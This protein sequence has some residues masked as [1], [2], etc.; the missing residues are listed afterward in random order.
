[1]R[2]DIVAINSALRVVC[3][4]ARHGKRGGATI[5]WPRDRTAAPTP[6]RRRAI[7]RVGVDLRITNRVVEV[8]DLIY[9]S[10]GVL[11]RVAAKNMRSCD[12]GPRSL[13]S[14]QRRR[15]PTATGP[16]TVPHAAAPPRPTAA[17]PAL[18]FSELSNSRLRSAL[19]PLRQLPRPAP[20]R[21]RALRPWR[22][23]FGA[24]AHLAAAAL[25]AAHAL[26]R[27]NQERSVRELA[28]TGHHR[29]DAV[30]RASRARAAGKR[31]RGRGGGVREARAGEWR[32]R[33]WGGIGRE[34]SVRSSVCT[35]TGWCGLR[36]RKGFQPPRR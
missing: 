14:K 10:V 24:L 33:G 1:M 22:L 28:K 12:C 3:A 23:L 19:R 9:A 13:H 31:G 2:R 20:R 27:E 16:P 35:C 21:R 15:S 8:T 7:I 26:R 25:Q 4:A 6:R 11:L 32:D 17:P 5:L 34:D 30:V 18:R 29:A 36:V